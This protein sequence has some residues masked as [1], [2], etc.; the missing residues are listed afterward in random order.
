MI[1]FHLQ[2][3]AG[4]VAYDVLILVQLDGGELFSNLTL[5]SETLDPDCSSSGD[6]VYSI[7]GGHQVWLSHL[8]VACEAE[9]TL[10]AQVYAV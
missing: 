6:E 9:I 8:L 3:G 7:V 2:A 4:Y 10:A 1:L 5:V